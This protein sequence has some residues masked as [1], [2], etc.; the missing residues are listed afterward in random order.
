MAAD[1]QGKEEDDDLG[2]ETCEKD[3]RRNIIWHPS[4]V[5][6]KRDNANELTCKIERNSQT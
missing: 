2:G 3:Q 5:E 1:H 6:S 4:Y